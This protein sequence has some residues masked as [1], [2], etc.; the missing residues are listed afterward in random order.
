MLVMLLS[1]DVESKPQLAMVRVYSPKIQ[2]CVTLCCFEYL[3]SVICCASSVSIGFIEDSL[4]DPG[5][6]C[7][8]GFAL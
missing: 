5:F 2:T 1:V 8:M 6:D 3:A 4:E 7:T